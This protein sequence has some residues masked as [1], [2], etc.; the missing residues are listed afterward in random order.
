MMALFDRIQHAFAVAYGRACGGYLWPDGTETTSLSRKP[1][2]VLV[3]FFMAIPLL[4]FA[5]AIEFIFPSYLRFL[6]LVWIG[7]VFFFL[8][9]VDRRAARLLM[10]N[11]HPHS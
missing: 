8:A 11:P 3:L 6:V 2:C 1:V 10:A 9:S 4:A 7:C 5:L